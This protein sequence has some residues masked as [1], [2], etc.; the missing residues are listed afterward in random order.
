[1][2]LQYPRESWWTSSR[3]G[4]EGMDLVEGTYYGS[5]DF[6]LV[7]PTVCDCIELFDVAPDKSSSDFTLFTHM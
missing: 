7:T 5:G 3:A 4:T 2:Y 6:N 1:M